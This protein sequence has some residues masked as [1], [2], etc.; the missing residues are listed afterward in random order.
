MVTFNEFMNEKDIVESKD[1][2]HLAGLDID[3]TEVLYQKAMRAK[4]PV[5]LEKFMLSLKTKFPDAKDIDFNK[6]DWKSLYKDINEST[7]EPKVITSLN[8][9]ID[10][11]IKNEDQ[12]YLDILA[13]ELDKI[14]KNIKEK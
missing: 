11:A 6:L 2:Q 5:E 4:N 12:A 3:N 8:S 1:S 10:K 7:K 9:D 13:K 14:L